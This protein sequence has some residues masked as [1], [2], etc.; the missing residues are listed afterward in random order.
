[1]PALDLKPLR[2]CRITMM[3]QIRGA[4]LHYAQRLESSGYHRQIP[5]VDKQ[6]DI[7]RRKLVSMQKL[8]SND[9]KRVAVAQGA[10]TLDSATLTYCVRTTVTAAN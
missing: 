8:K 9:F 4:V 3:Q 6:C 10:C 7:D 2:L 1:M 5:E